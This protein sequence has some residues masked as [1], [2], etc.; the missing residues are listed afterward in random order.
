MGIETVGVVGAG[1][2]G[3]GIAQLAL[4]AGHTVLLFDADPA[5]VTRGRERI[6]EGLG[7][8]ASRLDL[9]AAAMD[10][11]VEE[12][13][14]RCSP[15]ATARDLA[16][17]SDLVIEAVIEDLA[18]K[19]ALFRA[20]DGGAPPDTILATN[21][22]AL[23]VGAIAAGTR[24]PER[25]VGMHFFNPAPLMGLVEVVVAPAT[26]PVVADR[27]CAIVEAWGKTAVRC[28]DS[29]GF[30]VNRVN[31]PFTL[32]ALDIVRAGGATV[33]RI[34]RVVGAAGFPMGPFE[35]M[36]LVGLDINLAAARGIF[37]AFVAAGDSLADRSRPSPIQER[38]VLAGHLGRKMGGGFYAYDPTGRPTGP[39]RQWDVPEDP[40]LAIDDARIVDRIVLAIVNEAYR[41]LG[42]GVA[43]AA[44]IDLALPL[45][46][47]HAVG[48]FERVE[49]SGGPAA[50]LAELRRYASMGPRFVPAPALIAAAARRAGS[51]PRATI[52]S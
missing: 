27:A 11:W 43:T 15:V 1:T 9:D 32:E 38:M 29:P 2:M 28:T 10:G 30:I 6:R 5:A 31:R 3:S 36:D 19:Q 48:P 24:H 49:R 23:S 39:A 46:V 41:A 40:E 14:G 47:G 18:A 52:T 50:I 37:E 21:T 45:G 51:Q 12:R 20:F 35:L 33:D 8:R 34:D 4:Q 44:D 7:R 22:S 16:A 42:D 13:L 25:V 26:D 17:A